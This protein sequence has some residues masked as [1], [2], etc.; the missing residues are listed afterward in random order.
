MI[1]LSR[2]MEPEIATWDIEKLW[3]I[4]RDLANEQKMTEEMQKAKYGKSNIDIRYL[5]KKLY[6]EFPKSREVKVTSY[7]TYDLFEFWD[8]VEEREDLMREHLMAY[9]RDDNIETPRLGDEED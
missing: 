3:A 7:G 4:F 8:D 1:P 2:D 9:L 6:E 5:T